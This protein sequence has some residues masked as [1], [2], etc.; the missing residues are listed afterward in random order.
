MRTTCQPDYNQT[1]RVRCNFLQQDGSV[2]LHP[3]EP[4]IKFSSIKDHIH[5]TPLLNSLARES[6]GNEGCYAKQQYHSTRPAR[7]VEPLV[8]YGG[9]LESIV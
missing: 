5:W 7:D 2:Y 8:D 1:T 4:E 9:T 6:D 3:K